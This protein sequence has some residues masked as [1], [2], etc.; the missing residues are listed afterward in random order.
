MGSLRLQAILKYSKQEIEINLDAL[1]AAVDF[2]VMYGH[3]STGAK[4]Q[5]KYDVMQA[6]QMFERARDTERDIIIKKEDEEFQT[7]LKSQEKVD[8]LFNLGEN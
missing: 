1:S 6:M 4:L 8:D 7:L 3:P 2:F 5:Q